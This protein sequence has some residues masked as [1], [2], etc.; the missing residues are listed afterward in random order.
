MHRKSTGI[1]AAVI[2]AVGLCGCS[3]GGV[4][5][6][7]V[8]EGRISDYSCEMQ[9]TGPQSIRTYKTLRQFSETNSHLTCPFDYQHPAAITIFTKPVDG[10]CDEIT[11]SGFSNATPE[12]QAQTDGFQACSDV[13][14]GQTKKFTDLRVDSYVWVRKRPGG[15]VPPS[16]GNFSVALKMVSVAAGF[17]FIDDDMSNV[18][19]C[20]EERVGTDLPPTTLFGSLDI[21]MPRWAIEQ[22]FAGETCEQAI[23]AVAKNR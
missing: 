16:A 1:F 21:K 15:D 12:G 11:P 18:G 2:G 10:R 8:I 5:N 6:V 7:P 4:G 23:D 22:K 13:F 9:L 20:W 19:L 14:S 17:P 3:P